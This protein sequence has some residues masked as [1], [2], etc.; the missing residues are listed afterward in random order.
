MSECIVQL[1]NTAADNEIT[2]KNL[3][4]LYYALD[5]QIRGYKNICYHLCIDL[6]YYFRL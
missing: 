1:F 4:F 6:S 3:R 2:D 5:K